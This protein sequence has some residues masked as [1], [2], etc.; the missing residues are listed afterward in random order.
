MSGLSSPV[1]D[2]YALPDMALAPVPEAAPTRERLV[3]TALHL[4]AERGYSGVSNREIVEACGLTKGAIYWYFESKE[5]LF[6][7]IVGEA[8]DSWESRVAEAIAPASTPQEKLAGMFSLFVDVLDNPEDPHRDL[9][10]LMTHRQSAGPGQSA[11]GHA[12]QQRFIGWVR[13][14]ITEFEQSPASSDLADLVL[15]AGLGVL[16]QEASGHHVARPVLG[17]LLRLVGGGELSP[18]AG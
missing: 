18:A 10:I 1:T 14:V 16:V 5:H 8:L 15:T 9:L 6:R 13:G 11:L 17:A 12:S 2:A 7:T 3:R 4:F